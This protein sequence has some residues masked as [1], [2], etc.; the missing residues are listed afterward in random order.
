MA[1]ARY[2]GRTRILQ[3]RR[4]EVKTDFAEGAPTEEIGARRVRAATFYCKTR[5]AV[6]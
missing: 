1:F 6:L 5:T 3:R 2:F 4:R